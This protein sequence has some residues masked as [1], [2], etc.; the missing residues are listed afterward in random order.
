MPSIAKESAK[1]S[2]ARP[3]MPLR[4]PLVNV[5]MT[6][7]VVVVTLFSALVT[8]ASS[9]PRSESQS[10]DLLTAEFALPAMSS[11]CA[12]I[13]AEDDDEDRDRHRD[14]QQE[15]EH[16]ADCTRDAV[17]LKR[18]DQ[19]RGDGRHDPRRDHR[20]ADRVRSAEQP[21]QAGQEQH[22]ADEQPGGAAEVPQPAGRREH[23]RQ[24]RELRRSDR[25]SIAGGSRTGRRVDPLPE[26]HVHVPRPGVASTGRKVLGGSVATGRR[27]PGGHAATRHAYAAGVMFRFIR[28][29]LSG[30]YSALSRA[31][32]S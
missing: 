20:P 23:G 15:N 9:T 21:G 25:R 19:R 1:A 29:R 12:R 24:L 2:E 3:L 14:D 26:P 28:N 31:S 18:S 7:G 32:R 5:E 16:R 13:P 8:P 30:S 17:S 22:H 27:G 11:R 10:A 6:S 4:I